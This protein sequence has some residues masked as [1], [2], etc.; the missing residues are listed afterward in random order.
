VSE[1][2]VVGVVDALLAQL[3]HDRRLDRP[4]AAAARVVD[5]VLPTGCA[6]DALHGVWLGHPLH[7]LLTDL[8]IGCWT[9][10]MLFDLVPGTGAARAARLLIGLGCLAALPTAASGAADWSRL[11]PA[12]RRVGLVHAASNTLALGLYSW[13][14]RTRRRGRRPGG[15]L[16]AFAG[17][18]AATVGGHLGGHLVY[19]LGVGANRNADVQPPRE[20]TA[21][22]AP[23][24]GRVG[25]DATVAGDDVLVLDDA[26]I[27]ERCGHLGGPLADG[28]VTGAG[29]RRCVE[30]PWHGSVF[31]MDDGSVVHGPATA[32]QPAYAVERRAGELALRGRAAP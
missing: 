15:V 24:P 4:A 14:W 30:C 27:T 31:R 18:T 22:S 12:E 20:W 23:R 5:R 6:R 16:L 19:R 2:G 21:A 25:T 13:S 3:A 17:A 10:A 32:P 7:P 26:G 9:S 29:A 28:A 1:R 8:P 11:S